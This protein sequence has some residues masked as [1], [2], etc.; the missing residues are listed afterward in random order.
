MHTRQARRR[1]RRHLLPGLLR[2]RGGHVELRVQVRRNAAPPPAWW[3]PPCASAWSCW[4]WPTPLGPSRAATSIRPSPWASSS[5]GEWRSSRPS[6]SGSPSS[7][8]GSPGPSC[9]GASSR[10]HRI[11]SRHL[12]GLGADGFGT[13]SMININAVG[14]FFTEVILT[15]LFVYVVLAATSKLMASPAL[16][17]LAIGLALTVVHLIGIPITGTSVNPARSLGPGPDRGR[18]GPQSGL[19]LHR[20]PAHRGCDRRRAV[21]VLLRRSARRRPNQPPADRPAASAPRG[22]EVA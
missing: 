17:G 9:S 20:R 12:Q 18:P 3:R 22:A 15:F 1:V 7:W 2:G 13:L 16:A 6:S 19:A 8:A 5:P 4:P 11:Y 14:A 21:P 10:A